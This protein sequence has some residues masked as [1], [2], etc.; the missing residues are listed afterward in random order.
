MTTLFAITLFTIVLTASFIQSVWYGVS[1]LHKLYWSF[2][3]RTIKRINAVCMI[4][5]AIIIIIP[6]VLA[7]IFWYDVF[8]DTRHTL[9]I[10]EFVFSVVLFSNIQTQKQES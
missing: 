1:Q 4:P 9:T 10:F 7:H 3:I 5:V 6:A 2:S 8:F